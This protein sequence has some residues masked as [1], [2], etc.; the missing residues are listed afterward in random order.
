M[1]IG[2]I[3]AG[4]AG[5]EAA[6]AARAAGAEVTLF[7]A[8]GVLPYFRPRLVA[9]AFGQAEFEAIRMH[10][11]EWYSQQGITLRLNAR[12]RR[13]EA[14]RCEVSVGDETLRFDGLVIAAGANPT[15]PP[16]AAAAGPAIL[17]LWTVEHADAIRKL[18]RPDARITIIGGGILG[19]EAALRAVDAGLQVN[20]VELADRLMPAQFG[21]KASEVL[22]KRVS[23]KGIEVTLGHAVKSAEPITPEGGLFL[24]LDNGSRIEADLCL[25]SIGARPNRDLAEASGIQAERGLIVGP[26]LK[27]S[28]ASCFA[29]GDVIQCQGVTRCSVRE[30]STQGRIAGANVVASLRGAS[31]Q[32][33]RPES[34]PLMFRNGDFELYSIGQPGGTGYEE[35]LLDG[36]TA[37]VLRA[38]IEKDGLPVGAQMI[39]TRQGFEECAALVRKT[40]EG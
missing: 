37:E 23:A 17:P 34:Q 24:R 26:D 30:A 22:L 31:L 12:V 4:H 7:S 1:Q 39:G 18:V 15:M 19:L 3:G 9:L 2:I 6:R 8:E 14:E 20:L 21:P 13:V 33:Y 28:A 25:V 11:A 35:H 10:P 5:V 16:F 27:T 40:Q 32:Q 38:L 29:A 36:T